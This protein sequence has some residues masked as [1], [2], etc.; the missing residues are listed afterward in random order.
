MRQTGHKPG[1]NDPQRRVTMFA[2]TTTATFSIELLPDFDTTPEEFDCYDAADMAAFHNDDWSYVGVRVKAEVH[3][4]GYEL[5][6]TTDG[7]WGV[8]YGSHFNNNDAYIRELA[9][10]Q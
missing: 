1:H 4:V 2:T 9:A 6:I 8:E 7:L 3:E 5:H 10:E